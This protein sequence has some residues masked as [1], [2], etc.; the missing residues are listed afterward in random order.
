MQIRRRES[1]GGVGERLDEKEM[2][3]YV[4]WSNIVG[5]FCDL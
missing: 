1:S 4:K 3:K 5:T 2:M